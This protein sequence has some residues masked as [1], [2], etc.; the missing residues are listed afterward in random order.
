[1][2]P[3]RHRCKCLHC[4][5]FFTPDCRNRGRQKY[6]STPECRAASKRERQRRWLR[7]PE[8][9]DYFC[10]ESN[11]KRVQESLILA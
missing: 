9:R 8:N 5:E 4:K 6:C 11:V 3:E 1:M 7:K 2:K 10:G